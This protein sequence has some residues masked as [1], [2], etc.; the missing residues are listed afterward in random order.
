MFDD[1]VN[2]P[3][4]QEYKARPEVENVLDTIHK[5]M[6]VALIDTPFEYIKVLQSKFPYEHILFTNEYGL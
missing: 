4:E 1:F 3:E 2:S 5:G 6:D